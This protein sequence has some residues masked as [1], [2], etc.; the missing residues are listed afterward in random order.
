[1]VLLDLFENLNRFG[2]E[3]IYCINENGDP[4]HIKTKAGV[5]NK[6]LLLNFY[7]E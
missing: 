7:R 1:M 2:F 4:V 5:N 6:L 3:R